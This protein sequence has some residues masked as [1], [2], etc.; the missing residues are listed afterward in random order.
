MSIPCSHSA[1][2]GAQVYFQ[3]LGINSFAAFRKHLVKDRLYRLT[4]QLAK[5]NRQQAGL[6]VIFVSV[7]CTNRVPHLMPKG[8][9][10]GQPQQI[11][12]IVPLACSHLLHKSKD[13]GY[14]IF[15]LVGE[16]TS[17]KLK[18]WNKEILWSLKDN[19]FILA[20]L[21]QY[22]FQ[23]VVWETTDISWRGGINRT[24]PESSMSSLKFHLCVHRPLLNYQ[25]WRTVLK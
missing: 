23:L 18:S 25:K 6:M 5:A 9:I 11:R 2:V 20:C 10:L 14:H 19:K 8:A 13:V 17:E 1:I 21:S 16:G 12:N 15:N 24:W 22:L 7:I 3:C 4:G